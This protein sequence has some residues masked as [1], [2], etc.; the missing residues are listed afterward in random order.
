VGFPGTA[1]DE[2][3]YARMVAEHYPIS[4]KLREI[5]PAAHAVLRGL[6]SFQRQMDEPF[7]SPSMV[8]NQD[9]WRYMAALGV[10]ASLNGAGG[11]EVFAGY[12]SEYLG[13]HARGLFARGR[14]VR[15]LRELGTFSEREANLPRAWARAAW[16]ML[17]EV[18]RKGLRPPGP[19]SESDPLRA[20]VDVPTA[21]DDLAGRLLDHL[22][23]HK[24]NYWLRSGNTSFMG[25]P[26]EVRLPLLD[27]RVVEWACQLPAEYLIRDGW[28]KWALRKAMEPHLPREVVWRRVK[29][30]FPFPLREWLIGSKSGLEFL[31]NGEDPPGLDRAKVFAAYDALAVSHPTYLW[32]CLSVLMWWDLCV[33]EQPEQ[34]HVAT[35]AGGGK[36]STRGHRVP[37]T[38]YQVLQTR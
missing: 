18:W 22:G 31:R 34:P 12:G 29:M 38:Q 32:R 15:G 14:L 19:P 11:D 3:P 26:I 16:W 13:P 36:G 1:W 20:V 33:K 6:G 9:I 17:P 37:S 8:P 10:R 4:L 35:P 5:A 2:T 28:M 27:V 25:V 7:H 21:S 30:G 24:M 23:D